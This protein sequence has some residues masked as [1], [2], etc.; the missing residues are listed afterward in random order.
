MNIESP[1]RNAENSAVFWRVRGL[2]V[3]ASNCLAQASILNEKTLVR[4]LTGF[5]EI[6]A[7]GQLIQRNIEKN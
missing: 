5:E 2:S 1:L 4:R 7:L 6:L 3:R